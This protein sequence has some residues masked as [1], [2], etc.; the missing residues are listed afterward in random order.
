MD[1]AGEW[2]QMAVPEG[3]VAVLAG[4]TLQR[5]TCG[6]VTAA[7]HRMVYLQCTP[8]PHC[9]I[10]IVQHKALFCPFSCHTKAKYTQH[11]AR[12]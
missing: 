10:G 1:S 9:S 3:Q 11:A 12:R 6:L 7:K 5:A 4:Y 8:L 2:K